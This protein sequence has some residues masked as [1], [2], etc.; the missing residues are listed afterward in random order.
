LS[1][2]EEDSLAV[3]PED[4]VVDGELVS[5]PEAEAVL[6]AEP[7]AWAV[8]EERTEEGIA[9]PAEAQSFSAKAMVSVLFML[10]AGWVDGVGFVCRSNVLSWSDA[11]QAVSTQLLMLLMKSSFLQIHE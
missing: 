6:E 4:V 9:A 10:E 7:E 1:A 2:A 5:E 3:A 11:L 8:S